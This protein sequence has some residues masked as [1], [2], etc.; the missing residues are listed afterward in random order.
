MIR[1]VIAD[2]HD[3]FLAGLCSILKEEEHIHISGIARNG[4]EVMKILS[5][6]PC[7]VILLD[8][9]MPHQDGLVTAFNILNEHQYTKVIMITMHY[10]TILIEKLISMGIQGY[11]LKNSTKHELLTAIVK[12][13]DGG[14]YYS[15]EVT[16]KLIKKLREP[17]QNSFQLT[18]REKEILDLISKGMTSAEICA[19]LFISH[20]TVDT[21]RKKLLTK[22]GT[23]NAIELVSW[24][25]RNDFIL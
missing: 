20:H 7:D 9:E 25:R 2:D 15:R 21:H 14:L 5:S 18:K 3:L 17:R 23:K 4:S 24:A 8:V 11:L 22:S 12:I 6:N 10:N 16:E 19:H 13:H 1:V